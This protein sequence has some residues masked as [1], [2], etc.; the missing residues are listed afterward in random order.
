MV[1]RKSR[2]NNREEVTSLSK[3]NWIEEPLYDLIKEKMPLPCVDLLVIHNGRLLLMLRNNEPG[4][5]FW[6]TPGGRIHKNESLK[7]AVIRVLEKETGLKAD[8][9]CQIGTMSHLWPNVH[10][11]TTYFTIQVNS[12]EVKP[13]D[14]HRDYRWVNRMS[15]SFHPFVVEMLFHA[16]IF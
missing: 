16:E 13:N 15:P 9:I 8:K 6:F 12:E 11:V 14:E 3:E 4:K 7:A 2:Y 5:D 1:P 10:T